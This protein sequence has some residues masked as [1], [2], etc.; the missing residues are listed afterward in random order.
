MSWR[1]ALVLLVASVAQ[2]GEPIATGL[3]A[4]LGTH[5]STGDYGTS[6]ATDILYVPLLVRGELDRWTL[7]LTIPYLWIRSGG[8]IV[9]GPNG[10][11]Q[12]ESGVEDGLGDI[13]LRGMY[14]LPPARTRLPWVDLAGLVKFPS[15]SRARGL[16]TGAFDYGLETTVTW[17]I[18]RLTPFASV[19]YRFLGSAPDIALDDV[20]TAAGGAQVRVLDT[21]Y[22][23]L[24][25]DWRE[26]ASASSG[27]RLELVPIASWRVDPHWSVSGYATAGLADGSPDAGAGVSLGYR[28]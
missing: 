26:V 6:S 21:I 19:G 20:V 10:P 22:A 11:I 8:G 16:G 4:T 7:E 9:Q 2:A 15:A 27:E 23:G 5:Y 24:M 3:D 14:T 28:F 17:T 12:A 25:I 13:L 18:D 1:A